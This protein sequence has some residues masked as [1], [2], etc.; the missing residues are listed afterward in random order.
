MN[1]RCFMM[2]IRWLIRRNWLGILEAVELGVLL[3]GWAV[4]LGALAGTFMMHL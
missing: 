1:I 4:W 3:A 2:Q